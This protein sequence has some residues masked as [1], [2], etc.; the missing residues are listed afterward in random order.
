MEIVIVLLVAG[1]AA[2][3]F[4][5]KTRDQPSPTSRQPP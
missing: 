1:V 5:K 2:W 3:L 4:Y